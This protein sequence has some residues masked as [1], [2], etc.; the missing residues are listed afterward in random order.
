MDNKGMN[1]VLNYQKKIFTF[2]L[3][4]NRKIIFLNKF[5]CNKTQIKIN[6]VSYF[7]FITLK[8]IHK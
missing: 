2:M 4:I 5:K 1:A 6:Q 7:I 3:M 8:K